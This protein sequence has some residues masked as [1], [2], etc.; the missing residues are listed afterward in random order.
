MEKNVSDKKIPWDDAALQRLNKIPSFVR[1][2]AKKKI[3]KEAMAEG[4][5]R[6]T[7]IFIDANKAKLMG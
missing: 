4:E 2:M 5:E 1:G 3:E 6:I 7:E